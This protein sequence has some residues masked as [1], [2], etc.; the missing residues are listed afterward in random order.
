MPSQV[1]VATPLSGG[2]TMNGG[3]V[4][5]GGQSTNDSDAFLNILL[6]PTP[7]VFAQPTPAAEPSVNMNDVTMSTFGVPDISQ[8]DQNSQSAFLTPFTY[9]SSNPRPLQTPDPNFTFEFDLLDPSMMDLSSTFD[10]SAPFAHP[11]SVPAA[12]AHSGTYLDQT[13]PSVDFQVGN[14]HQIMATDCIQPQPEAYETPPEVKGVIGGWFDP[15]D[16]PP[17]VR[18]HL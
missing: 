5:D 17:P 8:Y 12:P 11:A 3:Q 6:Q 16:V 13:P 2:Q 14:S 7:T 10:M 1:P 18:D 15:D 9:Q 4:M